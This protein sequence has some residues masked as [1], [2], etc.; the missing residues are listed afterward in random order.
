MHHGWICGAKRLGKGVSIVSV[1]FDVKKFMESIP[2]REAEVF[3]LLFDHIDDTQ[4]VR[5]IYIHLYGAG[6]TKPHPHMVAVFISLLRDKLP[7]HLAIVTVRQRGY[8][9]QRVPEFIAGGI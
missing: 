9:M 7:N 5:E 2:L 4:T 8:R 3:K 1:E 6:A